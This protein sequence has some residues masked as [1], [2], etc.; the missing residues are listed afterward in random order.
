[1]TYG[2]PWDLPYSSLH[3]PCS[4]TFRNNMMLV[5]K[6]VVYIYRLHQ[7]EKAYILSMANSMVR[8]IDDIHA[9]KNTVN[10]SSIFKPHNVNLD[11]FVKNMELI[12]HRVTDMKNDM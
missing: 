7:Q 9:R 11:G 2:H 4:Y 3:T 8:W 5:M 12:L 10:Y 6:P 1:M